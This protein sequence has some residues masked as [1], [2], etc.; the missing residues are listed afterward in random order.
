MPW[1]KKAKANIPYAVMIDNGMTEFAGR[2]T[3][4][5]IAI[6]PAESKDLDPITGELK[7]L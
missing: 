5:C 7:L 6:G 2:K 4:T 1:Q 3:T